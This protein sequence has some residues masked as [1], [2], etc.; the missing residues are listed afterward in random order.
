MTYLGDPPSNP[1]PSRCLPA[2]AAQRF[3]AAIAEKGALTS[4]IADPNQIDTIIRR[5]HSLGGLTPQSNT[6]RRLFVYIGRKTAIFA[7]V[8]NNEICTANLGPAKAS[9]MLLYSVIGQPV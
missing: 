4:D 7:Y 9:I 2:D 5:I 3:K 8:Q 1:S 6:V